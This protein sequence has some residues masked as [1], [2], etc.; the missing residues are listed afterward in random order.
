M[1]KY[2]CVVCQILEGV[3]PALIYVLASQLSIES[4]FVPFLG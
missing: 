3:M 1:C 4:F 2:V